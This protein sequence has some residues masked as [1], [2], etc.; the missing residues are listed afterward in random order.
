MAG[1]QKFD[2]ELF[3]KLTIEHLLR[4][5]ETYKKT[6]TLGL[7][8][9]MNQNFIDDICEDVRFKEWFEGSKSE[10]ISKCKSLY[11]KQYQ[12]FKK[13]QEQKSILPSMD[14]DNDND[15]NDNDE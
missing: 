8:S 1:T 14:T 13:L 7:I 5:S 3:K 11:Q 6:K 9:F 15:N 4:E 10:K 2:F 12:Q